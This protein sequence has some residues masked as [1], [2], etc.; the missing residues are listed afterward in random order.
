VCRS[1]AGL[2]LPWGA[3]GRSGSAMRVA[4]R[5]ARGVRSRCAS[6]AGGCVNGH[7]VSP[8][9]VVGIC[10]AHVAR[11]LR[12]SDVRFYT[13]PMPAVGCAGLGRQTL[14]SI[15]F[16]ASRGAVGVPP[17]HGV[18]FQHRTPVTKWN[19]WTVPLCK[20][21]CPAFRTRPYCPFEAGA[22]TPVQETACAPPH[23]PCWP[24]NR[25]GERIGVL[26]A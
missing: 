15:G 7:A 3:A 8:V 26:T 25:P 12:Q 19:S 10:C 16:L 24:C 11:R 1:R 18:T 23:P 4:G 20:R 13:R 17:G 5:S 6:G 2:P 14:D 9:G 21:Y 22:M